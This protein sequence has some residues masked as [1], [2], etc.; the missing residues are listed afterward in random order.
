MKRKS[1]KTFR[2]MP[3]QHAASATL[4]LKVTRDYIRGA[5]K[6]LKRERL[7]RADCGDALAYLRDAERDAGRYNSEKGWANRKD[8]K[9][10]PFKSAFFRVNG[11]LRKTAMLLA[12]KCFR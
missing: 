4:A 9:A 12:K 1:K 11:Q 3:G 10:R 5:N 7:S 2:G 8:V 6:I